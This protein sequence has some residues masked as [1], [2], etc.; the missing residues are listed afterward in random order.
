MLGVVFRNFVGV[1][2]DPLGVRGSDRAQTRTLG[3]AFIGGVLRPDR[4]IRGHETLTATTKSH[5][6]VAA[7]DC[8]GPCEV[9][10][11]LRF[12]CLALVGTWYFSPSIS[13]A[14]A[15]SGT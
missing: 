8:V 10:S 13:T 11:E 12:R 2:D 6:V 1:H 7:S 5:T 4:R 14:V 9:S 3:G 15:S